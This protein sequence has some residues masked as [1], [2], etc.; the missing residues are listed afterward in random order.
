MTLEDVQKLAD[1]YFRT[2]AMYYLVV[3]DAQTQLDRLTGL[4]FGEPILLNDVE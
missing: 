1:N 4:G 2:D 3:G